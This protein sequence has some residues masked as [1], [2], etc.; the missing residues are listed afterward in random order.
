MEGAFLYVTGL[1]YKYCPAY[2][3]EHILIYAT[4]LTELLL[5]IV[6]CSNS[7]C[8]TIWFCDILN[9]YILAYLW[10]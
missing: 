1:L 9:N 5:G 6:I 4:F 7:L 10:L 2:C 8:A 3:S